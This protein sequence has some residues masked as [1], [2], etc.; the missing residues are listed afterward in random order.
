MSHICFEGDKRNS[1]LTNKSLSI[2][3]KRIRYLGVNEEEFEGGS[4]HVVYV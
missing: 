1:E 4:R 3:E 2:R